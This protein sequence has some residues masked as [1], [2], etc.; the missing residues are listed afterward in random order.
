MSIYTVKS[1]I[2]STIMV[3]ED[4]EFEFSDSHDAVLVLN[5]LMVHLRII[6]QENDT[7]NDYL[8]QKALL[9]NKDK[10]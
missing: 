9:S 1:V 2:D 5:E 8:E 4:L 7:Y 6:E 10:L 3:L